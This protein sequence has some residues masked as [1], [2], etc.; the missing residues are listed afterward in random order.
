METNP[1]PM[2]ST[3]C[4]LF[5]CDIHYH[6][7]F[8][9]LSHLANTCG[10][11]DMT[12]LICSRKKD[13]SSLR[14]IDQISASEQHLCDDFAHLLLKDGVLVHKLQTKYEGN[15]DG[16]VREVFRTWLSQDDDTHELVPCTWKDLAECIAHSNLD[17]A[18]AKAIRD[19][20]HSGVFISM[21]MITSKCLF[22][23]YV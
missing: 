5:V 23:T 17:G 7:T 10:R 21:A 8:N 11:P 1:G 19:T 16:F 20:F 14:I 4:E 15:K 12:Q 18:L 22:Y 13:G 2:P 3:N 6:C 9:I